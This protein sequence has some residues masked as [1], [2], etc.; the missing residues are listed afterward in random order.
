MSE[1]T[2][3]SSLGDKL[4][5]EE[6]VRKV[7]SFEGIADAFTIGTT[8]EENKNDL[9][10]AYETIKENKVKASAKVEMGEK[11]N[12]TRPDPGFR[13]FH[14]DEETGEK[15]LVPPYT[16]EGAMKKILLE[17]KAGTAETSSNS[18][19][20]EEKS[21]VKEEPIYD[22]YTMITEANASGN[23]SDELNAM[24]AARMKNRGITSEI[25]ESLIGARK[26]DDTNADSLTNEHEAEEKNVVSIQI[27]I[28]L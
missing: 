5:I 8:E 1:G 11:E 18:A 7:S 14:V 21:E 3:S 16:S 4:D 6:E 28:G 19:G 20:V 9:L 23:R 17:E 25:D 24:R 12:D 26:R 27:K 22:G 10:S 15:R 13:I 2:K